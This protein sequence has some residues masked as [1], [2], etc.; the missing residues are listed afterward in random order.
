MKVYRPAPLQDFYWDIITDPTSNAISR[1]WRGQSDKCP[2]DPS[3]SIR[4]AISIASYGDF[5]LTVS[6]NSKLRVWCLSTSQLLYEETLASENSPLLGPA[7]S[8]ILSIVAPSHEDDQFYF[9]TYTPESVQVW[10]VLIVTI[11]EEI[12]LTVSSL[13]EKY[14]IEPLI[15][16]DTSTWLVNSFHV[17]KQQDVFSITTLL[18]SNTSS[19]IHKVQLPVSGPWQVAVLDDPVDGKYLQASASQATTHTD[20]YVRWLLGLVDTLQQLL[21]QRLKFT[22]RIMQ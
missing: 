8:N 7:P 6:I 4:T 22:A 11:G 18:K 3:I 12:A 14:H 19:A 9:L 15:P 5:L 17:T 21:K 16:D 20:G 1:L 10:S 2:S 13:G